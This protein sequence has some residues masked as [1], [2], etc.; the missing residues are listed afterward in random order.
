[1]K[2]RISEEELVS[3]FNGMGWDPYIV[4]ENDTESMHQSMAY[5]LDKCIQDINYIKKCKKNV[6]ISYPMIILK[7]PKGWGGPKIIDNNEI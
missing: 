1:M 2:S 4:S 3:Y 5:A 6:R 7:T